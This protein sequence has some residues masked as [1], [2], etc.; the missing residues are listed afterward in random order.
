MKSNIVQYDILLNEVNT[1]SIA[2]Q[3]IFF[4]LFVRITKNKTNKISIPLNE[5]KKDSRLTGTFNET[6]YRRA[7]YSTLSVA[8][9]LKFFCQTE[10]YIIS[11]P[12]FPVLTLS[13]NS[14]SLIV[15]TNGKKYL[16]QAENFFPSFALPAFLNL[17]SRY[18][19]GLFRALLHHF[20][21]TCSLSSEE[22]KELLQ[23]KTSDQYKKFCARLSEIIEDVHSSNYFDELSY[24]CVHTA[25]RGSPIERF[26]FR[27]KITP[28]YAELLIGHTENDVP[29]VCPICGAPRVSHADSQGRYW[30]FC[31]N[32]MLLHRGSCDCLWNEFIGVSVKHA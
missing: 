5:L 11:R 28:K 2:E 18:A 15:E 14:E 12:L 17:H 19:K 8:K 16:R 13:D 4:A 1:L 6:Q 29:S 7:L 32:S 31:D 30:D 22:L 21:G 10:N 9:K 27:Y 23:L 26:I 20:Y 24:E 25:K 3:N